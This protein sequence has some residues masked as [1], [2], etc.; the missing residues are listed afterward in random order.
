MTFVKLLT[1]YESDDM[2]PTALIIRALVYFIH[3]SDK[4]IV[5]MVSSPGHDFNKVSIFYHREFF[6]RLKEKVTTEATVG[7][8]ESSPGIPPRVK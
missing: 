2:N 1:A 6:N 8:M 7:V 5:V 4:M 3:H